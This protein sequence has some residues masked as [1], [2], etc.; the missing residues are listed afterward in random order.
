[1]WEMQIHCPVNKVSFITV[2]TEEAA[3][4]YCFH[5]NHFSFQVKL[6]FSSRITERLPLQCWGLKVA[7]QSSQNFHWIK[8]WRG[9]KKQTCRHPQQELFIDF[10][11]S[12]FSLITPG[13]PAKMKWETSEETLLPTWNCQNQQRKAPNPKANWE[14][15][16]F[17]YRGFFCGGRS[18]VLLLWTP[19][20][21]GGLTTHTHSQYVTMPFLHRVVGRETRRSDRMPTETAEDHCQVR[22]SAHPHT[23]AFCL[24]RLWA[25]LFG[26]WDWNAS[27]SLGE[28]DENVKVTPYQLTCRFLGQMNWVKTGILWNPMAVLLQLVINLLWANFTKCSKTKSMCA[29]KAEVGGMDV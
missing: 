4:L 15:I 20:M 8:Q 10:H 2:C 12:H 23:S 7:D 18:V 1:M 17:N 6:L 19:L 11:G 9:G 27:L 3:N 13:A 5:P 24:P 21:A 28:N 14:P 16:S 25:Y 29:F 22:C 26:R